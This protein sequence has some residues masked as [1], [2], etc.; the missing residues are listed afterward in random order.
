VQKVCEDQLPWEARLLCLL[1][2]PWQMSGG[3]SS[4]HALAGAQ[5]VGPY[6]YFSGCSMFAV[7]DCSM[8]RPSADML[9]EGGEA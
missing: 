1:Q 3:R 5:L 9:V 6:D 4:W 7:H 2:L 8:K